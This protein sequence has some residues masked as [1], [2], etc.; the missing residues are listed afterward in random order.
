MSIVIEARVT[1]PVAVI[2]IV[3]GGVARVCEIGVS[4]HEHSEQFVEEFLFFQYIL[5]HQGNGAPDY[6]TGARHDRLRATASTGAARGQPFQCEASITAERVIS[7]HSFPAHR[8]VIDTVIRVS[9]GS[10]SSH[11][12]GARHRGRL[13][14][15]HT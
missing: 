10:T 13:R 5:E 9:R 2:G 3:T 8:C 1:R 12:H 4:V 11:G 6:L 14:A 15:P 7:A